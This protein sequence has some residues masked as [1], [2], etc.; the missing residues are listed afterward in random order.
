MFEDKTPQPEEGFPILYLLFMKYLFLTFFILILGACERSSDHNNPQQI[1]NPS[2]SNLSHIDIPIEDSFE[3]VDSIVP[4]Y[5][6]GMPNL[7]SHYSQSQYQRDSIGQILYHGEYDP[8]QIIKFAFTHYER[9]YYD[10][11]QSQHLD[12]AII[13][14]QW[15]LDNLQSNSTHC[16]WDLHEETLNE[17]ITENPFKSGMTN[18]Q[19]LALLVALYSHLDKIDSSIQCLINSFAYDVQSDGVASISE[20]KYWIEEYALTSRSQILN[21]AIFGALGLWYAAEYLDSQNAAL[22]WDLFEQ[23]L[24]T[25]MY[26]YDVGYTSLYNLLEFQYQ[27]INYSRKAHNQYNL[28]HS[29]QLH[30]LSR[31]TGKPSYDSLGLRMFHYENH[32]VDSIFHNGVYQPKLKSNFRF[33]GYSEQLSPKEWVIQLQKDYWIEELIL[34]QSGF[35]NDLPAILIQ[36]PHKDFYVIPE[37]VDHHYT[38]PYASTIVRYVIPSHHRF[39]SNEIRWSHPLTQSQLDIY[40]SGI[41]NIDVITSDTSFYQ[42]EMSRFFDNKGIPDFR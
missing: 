38:E 24:F 33:S 8:R 32:E 30:L 36:G 12:T 25:K 23:N 7:E 5:L 14:A 40:G 37:A 2:D 9:W 3:F 39:L 22:L 13:Q 31:L 26:E 19:G 41:R 16:W 15:L 21:G 6:M 17:V 1:I 28:I 42:S 4:P 10:T 20:D 11:T 29:S 34:Y 18:G 27:S 35:V